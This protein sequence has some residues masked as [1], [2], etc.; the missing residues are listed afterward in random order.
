LSDDLIR[1]FADH[2]LARATLTPPLSVASAVHTTDAML[3]CG[4]SS[5]FGRPSGKHSHDPRPRVLILQRA[6]DR[7]LANVHTLVA[8]LRVQFASSQYQVC[9]SDRFHKIDH[10]AQLRILQETK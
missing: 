10:S 8:S 3:D 9:F 1:R 2:F 6:A 7:L 4:E 5:S